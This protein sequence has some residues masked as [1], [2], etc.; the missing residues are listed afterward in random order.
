M[1]GITTDAATAREKLHHIID[2][3]EDVRVINL[4]E[5][6]KDEDETFGDFIYTGEVKARIAKVRDDYA[7]GRMENFLNEEQFHD[8]LKHLRSGK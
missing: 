1:L 2:E 7:N 4:Y 8:E 3:I 6:L 5:F